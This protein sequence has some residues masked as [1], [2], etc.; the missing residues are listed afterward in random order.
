MLGLLG[1]WLSAGL[2]SEVWGPSFADINLII[3]TLHMSVGQD[4]EKLLENL[5]SM[6]AVG[7]FMDTVKDISKVHPEKSNIGSPDFDEYFLTKVYP[8]LM[9]GLEDLAHEVEDWNEGRLDDT[10]TKRFNPCFN[11][12]QFLMRN[13][14]LYLNNAEKYKD[15]HIL[16][17]ELKRRIIEEMKPQ[18]LS[19]IEQRLKGKT[20]P[21]DQ[22]V[23]VFIEVDELLN[24][25]GKLKASYVVFLDDRPGFLRLLR[26]EKCLEPMSL[27]KC[28]M[29]SSPSIFQTM[30]QAQKTSK[31]HFKLP[32]N[33]TITYF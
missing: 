26:Q 16:T 21:I 25:N 28:S 33:N 32:L 13:N 18:L 6:F 2:R 1:S 5:R 29:T 17:R 4:R 15:N 30:Q 19:K 20:Y 10:E 7:G 8:C 24:A 11:L 9:D 23:D 22:I 14:P 31:S 3:N 27:H 12:A